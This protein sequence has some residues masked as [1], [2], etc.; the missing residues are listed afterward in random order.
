MSYYSIIKEQRLPNLV[1]ESSNI[2]NIFNEY[3]VN[4]IRD[5]QTVL[6]YK[7][8]EKLNINKI[9]DHTYILHQNKY[10]GTYPIIIEKIYFKDIIS[11]LPKLSKE[12][13]LEVQTLYN[14]VQSYNKGISIIP[15]QCVEPQIQDNNKEKNKIKAEKEREEE[16]Q[17]IFN[18]DKKIYLDF[19]NKISEGALKEE[20]I[21]SLFVEKYNLFKL[22]DES[23]ILGLPDEFTQYK[24]ALLDIKNLDKFYEDKELYYKAKSDITSNKRTFE[25]LPEEFV[26]IYG[27]MEYMENEDLF[28]DKEYETFCEL[29]KEL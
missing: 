28:D 27:I 13:Q 25:S 6:N 7:K 22:L 2:N 12:A 15:I 24:A 26:K 17:N 5:I 8:K 16:L 3:L 11:H 1:S 23:E 19:K 10:N 18:C 29:L 9:I 4:I 14:M 21:P 20:N